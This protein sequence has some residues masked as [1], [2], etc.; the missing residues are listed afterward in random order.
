RTASISRAESSATGSARCPTPRRAGARPS[1]DTPMSS[2]Y[3]NSCSSATTSKS[4]LPPAPANAFSSW[5]KTWPS[6]TPPELRRVLDPSRQWRRL[7]DRRGATVQPLIRAASLRGFGALVSEL[8]CEADHLLE[9]FGIAPDVRE[10]DDGLLSITSHDR[11]LDAAADE[12]SC[13]DLGLRLAER[14]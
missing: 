12:L 11:M 14:Q 13:P 3:A 10:S 5:Q 7:R 4:S 6:E 1:S 9:R 8:G 2:R